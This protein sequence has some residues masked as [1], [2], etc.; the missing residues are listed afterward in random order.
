MNNKENDL[1]LKQMKGVTPIKRN[2][3][4]LNRKKINENKIVKKRPN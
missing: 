3:R 1:F 4:T 2:N